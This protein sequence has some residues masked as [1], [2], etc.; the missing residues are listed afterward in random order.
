[1]MKTTFS[2]DRDIENFLVF[3]ESLGH[4]RSTYEYPLYSF[5]D[6]F[7]QN[8]P[9]ATALTHEIIMDYMDQQAK[10]LPEKARV[11][12]AFGK[13]L[14]AIG[15]ESYVLPESMYKIPA[16]NKPYIFSDS[17]LSALFEEIDSIGM[18]AGWLAVVAPVLYRLIY[19]CGLRPK[20]A[21]E[22]RK[23]HINFET[24]EIFIKESKGKKDRTVV[25]SED[26]RKLCCSFEEKRII[27]GIRSEYFFAKPDGF[28]YGETI[29]NNTF[30]TC[31]K[32]SVGLKPNERYKQRIRVYCLRHRFAT[33]VIHRWIDEKQDLRNKLPYLQKYMGHNRIT[34]TIYYL[35]LLP[36]NLAK[37]TGID[38]NA[39]DGV[40]PEVW[41]CRS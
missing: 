11:L 7:L 14:V 13:Y 22:L 24:G 18:Q 9:T 34:D 38:W 30:V 20:E 35:H 15:R 2:I 36:E 1:M 3:Q 4:K 8:Y 33:A 12:R 19:T 40:I 26:M 37:S 17:E 29:I 39:F 23:R 41:K 5:K 21:R 25:M 32:R 10:G 31:W 27:A 6:F 16:N 28:P